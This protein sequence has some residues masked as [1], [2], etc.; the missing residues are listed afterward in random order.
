MPDPR[1]FVFSA[2]SCLGWS[3]LPLFNIPECPCTGASRA[4][5]QLPR[6][7]PLTQNGVS[8]AITHTA[9]A[10]SSWDLWPDASVGIASGRVSGLVVL[11]VDPRHDGD[12]AHHHLVGHYDTLPD[13]FEAA[14]SRWTLREALTRGLPLST[15]RR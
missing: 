5:C 8:D 14:T 4:A 9:T 10:A 2:D 11:D 15:F 3:V 13:T 6:E 1:R 12:D 7:Y